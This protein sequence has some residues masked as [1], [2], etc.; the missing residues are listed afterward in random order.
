[1]LGHHVIGVRTPKAIIRIAVGSA[2]QMFDVRGL[3]L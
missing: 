2:T 3:L 1:M